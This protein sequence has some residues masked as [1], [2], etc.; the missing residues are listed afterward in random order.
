ME[1]GGMSLLTVFVLGIAATAVVTFS[2]AWYIKPHLKAILTDLCGT[3]VRASFWMAFSVICLIAVPLIFSLSA[4]PESA[5]DP[6]LAQL[7]GQMK[8]ALMGLI[9]TVGGLGAVLWSFIR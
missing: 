5:N 3:E 7:V 6:A 4:Y 9:A 8:W 1:G 2:V